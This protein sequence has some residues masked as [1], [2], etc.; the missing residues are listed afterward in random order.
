MNN[1]NRLQVVTNS[2]QETQ[3]VGRKIGEMLRSGDCVEL[4][5]DLGAGKTVFVK[6][7][8]QGIK[9]KDEVSSPS[10]ALKNIYRGRLELQH[11]DLYRLDEPGLM[12]DEIQEALSQPE[13]AV[14]IEWGVSAAHILPKKR[15]KIAIKPGQVEDSRTIIVEV[16]AV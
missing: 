1:S 7:L 8:A 13:T 6:G 3:A 15:Y 9:S 16:P 10:F 4:I 5:G 12:I 11:L 14:V 2:T